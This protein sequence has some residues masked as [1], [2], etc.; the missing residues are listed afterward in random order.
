VKDI[1][2][3]IGPAKS[4]SA[5]FHVHDKDRVQLLGALALGN[6]TSYRNDVLSIA[7]DA[8]NGRS[9]ILERNFFAIL[10]NES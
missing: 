8:G 4:E 6:I 3:E 10:S 9:P 7:S 5:L 2:V 1:A